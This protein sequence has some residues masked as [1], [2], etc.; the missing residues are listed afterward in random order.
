VQGLSAVQAQD[1]NELAHAATRWKKKK[2]YATSRQV[3]TGSAVLGVPVSVFFSFGFAYVCSAFDANDRLGAERLTALAP[4][5][6]A[7][8]REASANSKTPV[9]GVIFK[10]HLPLNLPLTHPSFLGPSQK[11]FKL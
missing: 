9:H 10:H 6:A 8:D 5:L 7:H 4:I 3:L 2:Y 11:F 1:A